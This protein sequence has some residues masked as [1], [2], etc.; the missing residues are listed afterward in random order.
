MPRMI[1]NFRY[2]LPVN[3]PPENAVSDELVACRVLTDSAEKKS[4]ENYVPISIQQPNRKITGHTPC[5]IASISLFK[6][7]AVNKARRTFEKLRNSEVAELVI[8]RDAGLWMEKEDGHIDFWPFK[9]TKMET[10]ETNYSFC[11]DTIDKWSS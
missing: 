10:Y 9:E 8:P 1:E 6:S 7:H 11:A 5:E 4:A 2:E 3:C